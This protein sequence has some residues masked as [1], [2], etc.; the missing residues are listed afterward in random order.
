[1]Y[2]E[3][4]L[5]LKA[6]SNHTFAKTNKINKNGATVKTSSIKGPN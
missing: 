5:P 3:Q 2:I 4:L 1:M 6:L